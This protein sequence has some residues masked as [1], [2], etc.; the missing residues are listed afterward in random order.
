MK[1]RDAMVRVQDAYPKIY[2]ACPARHQTAWT[3][4][5]RVSQRDASILS[6]LNERHP[7]SQTELVKHVGLAK[8]TVSEGLRGLEESGFV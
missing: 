7:V 8:S 4:M 5:A 1:V 2:L 6:R 3:N